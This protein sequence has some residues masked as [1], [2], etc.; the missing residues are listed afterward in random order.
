MY[1]LFNAHLP[2]PYLNC[3]GRIRMEMQMEKTLMKMMDSLSLMVTSL[4]MKVALVTL[5]TSLLTLMMM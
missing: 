4:T 3:R 1:T 5:G 2:H